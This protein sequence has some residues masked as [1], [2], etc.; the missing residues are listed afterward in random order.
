MTGQ[1]QTRA[2]HA[3]RPSRR[4]WRRAVVAL[5]AA[6]I[7]LALL[8]AALLPRSGDPLAALPR[9]ADLGSADLGAAAVT[10][11]LH[12]DGRVIR[13]YTI[14]DPVLGAIGFVV[15]LPDP[16]PAGPMPVVVVLGG[17]G[18]GL[19]NIRHVPPAGDNVL[20]G[21]DW[22]IPRKFPKGLDL[23]RDLPELY[24]G[25]FSVPGQIAAAVD[26]VAAQAWADP[27]RVSL[28]GF[29]LGAIAAPAAQRLLEAR[30]REV[31]WTVLAYGGAELGALVAHHPRVSPKAAAP[32]LGRLAGW[33]FRPLEPARHLPH[34]SGRFLVIGG[35]EDGLVPERSAR[36]M[37][38]LAPEPKTLRLLDGQHMG[39]GRGQE[40]LL[41]EILGITEA[42]LVAQGAVNPI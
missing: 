38:E 40:A 23:V 17:L 39:V 19:K 18:T 30:D 4:R 3:P 7:L 13:R 11:T 14:A 31:G 20:V 1:A 15:S 35:R 5:G 36:L 26:W 34:L 41:R 16:L 33:L 42:W 6:V 22:P 2:S 24:R 25:A 8:A 32:L 37:R 9:G 21:Y 29:S 28:L 27:A 10:E 12:E